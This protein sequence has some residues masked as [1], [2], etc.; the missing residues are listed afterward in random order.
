MT[1]SAA[2]IAH[3][4]ILALDVGTLSVRTALYDLNGN[5]LTM[6]SQPIKLNRLSETEVEQNPVKMR[7]R[8][9]DVMNQVIA[10]ASAENRTIIAAGLTTQRSSVVA[11]NRETGEPLSPILSW[12]DRRAAHYLKPLAS[13]GSKIKQKSGLFLTPYYGASKLRWLLDHCPQ[14]LDDPNLI[15]GPL[16]AFIVHSIVEGQPCIVDHVN[17]SRTQLLDLEMRDWSAGLLKNFNIEAKLL[18]RCQP[19]QSNYGFLAGTHIPLTAVNGDQNSAIHGSGKVD[20]DTFI[21]NIGTGAFVLLATGNRPI[22]HPRLLASIANSNKDGATYLLEGTVNSAGAA[23]NW[24][25]E[26]WDVPNI[27][28]RLAQWLADVD[29]PPIFINTIGGLGSP[30]WI[31]GPAARFIGDG[32]V[33]EKAVA[34]VESILFLIQINFEA[35]RNTGQLVKRIRISGGLSALDGLC[36]RLAD[37][38]RRAVVRSAETQST[39]RGIAWLASNQSESWEVQSEDVFLPQKNRSLH[40]RY[41][42][43]CT[44]LGWS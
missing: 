20:D 18:P 31:D 12:Q 21:V 44:E 36:Q 42:R 8:L 1:V 39:A 25:S 23:L 6:A 28:G 33:A 14:L 9:L 2:D 10:F 32:T 26:Q 4:S 3:Q 24:A 34:I 15:F 19:T 27:S 17:A 29:T 11:W 35:M 40:A 16:A 43:F 30:H 38:S 13:K 5:L 41:H 22:H 37:L 7:D